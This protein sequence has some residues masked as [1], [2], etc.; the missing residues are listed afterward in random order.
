[1][2]SNRDYYEIL[3]V[4]RNA[5]DE[6]LKKAFRKLAFKYHP[7]HNKEAA[8][9]EK[10]KEIN[11][12]YE[13]LSDAKKR[14]SYD[15]YGRVA[16]ADL[17]GFED[18]GFGGLGDI[19]DAFFGAADVPGATPRDAQL[20][21]DAALRARAGVNG[22]TDQFGTMNPTPAPVVVEPTQPPADD[23]GGDQFVYNP[24]TDPFAQDKANVF[25]ALYD[26]WSGKRLPQGYQDIMAGIEQSQG[27]ERDEAEQ[28]LYTRGLANSTL[29]SAERNR[30]GISQR[31]E[32]A[33]Q[34]TDLRS[35]ALQEA[36]GIT[37]AT[38]GDFNTERSRALNEF[39]SLLDRQYAGDAMAASQDEHMLS[40]LLNA[41]GIVTTPVGTSNYQVPDTTST[42]EAL[43]GLSGN[44]LTSLLSNPSINWGSILGM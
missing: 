43:G 1:M 20:A 19:F 11:E 2:L 9:E 26:M 35:K 30:L 18:F 12:A 28:G 38:A 23:L 10:F 13:V 41:M 15:R 27:T 29:G 3:G 33:A 5:S 17:F 40:L 22:D 34:A 6:E 24:P 44:V 21:Y 36:L 31:A 14:A 16:T 4:P 8:A 7:D 25:Q 42:G 32:T 39:L 37:G